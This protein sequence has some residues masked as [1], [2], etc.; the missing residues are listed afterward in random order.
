MK[1][2][3]FVLVLIVSVLVVASFVIA[4]SH[5]PFGDA[6]GGTRH[7]TAQQLAGDRVA[8]DFDSLKFVERRIVYHHKDGHDGGPG[9]GGPPG[10]GDSKCFDTFG[11]GVYWKVTE[12]YVVDPTNI[13]G[14]SDSFVTDTTATSFETWDSEVDFDVFGDEDINST[15][16]GADTESPDGKN[17][18]MFGSIDSP[19]AIAVAIVWGIFSGPPSQRKIVEYDVVFD[20]VDYDWGDA[21]DNSSLMD[22]QAI[23]THEFGH[24]AGLDDLYDDECSEETMFGFGSEG[25]TFQ[26]T[27]NAGDI[28]GIN[29]LYA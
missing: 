5:S 22:Y 10:G 7:I 23:A 15:V 4:Q 9:G 13:D 25:E 24:S 6:P 12:G 19:G 21:D 3:G 20:D 16:D 26:R 8:F 29:E 11:R 28:T 17:E 18:V 2:A 1:K 27:L 14:M